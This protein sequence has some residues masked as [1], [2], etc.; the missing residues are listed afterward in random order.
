MRH[1]KEYQ[2]CSVDIITI[3]NVDL[4]EIKHNDTKQV[5]HTPFENEAYKICILLN[6]DCNIAKL[7]SYEL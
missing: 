1:I 3:N 2:N 4:Y 6:R 7:Y 5:I